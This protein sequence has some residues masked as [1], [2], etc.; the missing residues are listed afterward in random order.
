MNPIL[1]NIVVE[2]CV[3]FGL[4]D[5]DEVDPDVAVTQLEQIASM[6]GTLS[7]ED[8]DRFVRHIGELAAK[9][10][11][12]ADGERQRVLEALPESLGLRL[13]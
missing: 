6:L 10:R 1:M 2:T 13:S 12:G 7:R 11:E 8:R 9:A 4:C 3:F 5:D